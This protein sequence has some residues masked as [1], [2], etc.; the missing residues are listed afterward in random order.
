MS[1]KLEQFKFFGLCYLFWGVLLYHIC[2]VLRKKIESN[3]EEDHF[4]LLKNYSLETDSECQ[5]RY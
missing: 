2:T 5:A 4:S 3:F 1:I